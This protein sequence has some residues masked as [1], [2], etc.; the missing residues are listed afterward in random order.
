MSGIGFDAEVVEHL[1]LALKRRTGKLA[2]AASIVGRL[3]AYRPCVL[4]AEVDGRAVEASSLVAAK[5]HFYGGR[6][7]LAPE[8]RLDDPSLHVVLFGKAGRA[9]ALGYLAAMSLGRLQRCRSL[10]ILPGKAVRLLA[11]VGAAVQ[12]DGDIQ[13]RLPARLAI[14]KTPLQLIHPEP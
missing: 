10:S 4:R 2:Y 1:D 12:L 3:R 14:A 9:A 6:F 8:A 7:V 11:P 5:A 13:L